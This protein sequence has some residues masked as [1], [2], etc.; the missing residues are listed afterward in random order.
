[1]K[2]CLLMSVVLLIGL[3]S[4]QPTFEPEVDIIVEGTWYQ[5]ASVYN[6]DHLVRQEI[7]FN[8]DG[9]YELATKIIDKLTKEDIEYF[10]LYT[11][12]YQI[13]GNRLRRLNVNH[14][15]RTDVTMKYS[16]QDLK[17]ISSN[18][19]L[20]IVLLSLDEDGETLT[21]DYR[22]GNCLNM[23][24]KNCIEVESYTRDR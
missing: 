13:Q 3:A 12:N 7:T 24:I 22:S 23:S 2:I 4:C 9:T 11:G 15:G 1:M 14:Y 6:T 20:P 21:M 8:N 19:E 5:A 10:F 18:E 16:R 17:L